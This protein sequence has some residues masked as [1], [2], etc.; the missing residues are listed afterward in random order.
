[1]A[2]A[3]GWQI[4]TGI[5][6]EPIDTSHSNNS[7]SERFHECLPSA[8]DKL[9]NVKV[10]ARLCNS[11]NW[12]REATDAVPYWPRL[13]Q[14]QTR[15]LLLSKGYRRVAETC[16]TTPKFYN[17][18]PKCKYIYIYTYITSK[19]RRQRL[20]TA[21]KYPVLESVYFHTERSLR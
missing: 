8:R 5:A 20:F 1:M 21:L 13:Q 16:V 9:R 6:S 19:A 14:N 17:H 3:P 15:W 11:N 2:N 18:R 10:L 7:I 12:R 4:L